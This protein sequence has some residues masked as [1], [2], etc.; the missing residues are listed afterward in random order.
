MADLTP[1]QELSRGFG[2][3]LSSAFELTITPLVM[4]LIGYGLDRW[5][6]TLPVFTA[7]WFFFT[8]GYEIWKLRKRYELQMLEH[9]GNVP[10]MRR[11]G[12]PD[13]GEAKP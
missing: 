7:F 10:G 9:E 5:L 6:G 8:L 11:P 1:K 4:G 3:A 12:A 2:D 13:D